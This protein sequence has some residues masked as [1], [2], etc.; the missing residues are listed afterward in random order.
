MVVWCAVVRC[1]VVLRRCVF[2]TSSVQAGA[3]Q[4]EFLCRPSRSRVAV[5]VFS[6]FTD[7][8]VPIHL[9]S[10]CIACWAATGTRVLRDEQ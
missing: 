1:V 9:L 7:C 5:A 10:W 8:T 6:V 3:G 2:F 4:R